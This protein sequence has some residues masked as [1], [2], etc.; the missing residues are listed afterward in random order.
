MEELEL[1]YLA[2]FLPPTLFTSPSKRTVDLYVPASAEHPT[3]RIRAQGGKQE[4]TKK[5][6]REGDASHQ[7]ESTITLSPEEYAAFEK[8]PYK[9]VVKTRYYYSSNGRTYE[10]DIFEEDLAGLVL[11][12]AEFETLAEKETFMAPN[13]CLVDVTQETFLA[14]GMLCGK[15]YSDI[16]PK[17][18]KLGYKKL[19]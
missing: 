15:K 13:F 11:V 5:P 14:G 9:R 1:T 19:F 2:K 8:I 18:L 4:I 10:F 12:D 16:E 6:I 3:L 7:L 17:L